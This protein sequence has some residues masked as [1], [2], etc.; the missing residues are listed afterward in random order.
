MDMSQADDLTAGEDLLRTRHPHY[1]ECTVAI[2]IDNGRTLRQH[3]TGTLFRFGRHSLLVT[4]SHVVAEHDAFAIVGAAG[5]PIPVSGRKL[6]TH[7]VPGEEFDFLDVAIWALED[8]TVDRL[9]NAVFLRQTDVVATDD[10]SEDAYFFSGYPA[11]WA[12]TE[13]ADDRGSL[14][15][16][17]YCTGLYTGDRGSFSGCRPDHLLLSIGTSTTREGNVR[18]PSWLGGISGCSVW[19]SYVRSQGINEGE[20][21]VVAVQTGVYRKGKIVKATPRS[22]V[23]RMLMQCFPDLRPALSLYLPKPGRRGV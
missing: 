5:Q 7:A 13:S 2:M 16:L 21:K 17:T 22:H 14:K 1:G 8:R 9:S 19:R 15:L 3:G 18:M 23:G 10:L 11:E 20:A 6:T 12:D 4:A